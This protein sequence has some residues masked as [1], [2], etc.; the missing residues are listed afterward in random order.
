MSGKHLSQGVPRI[1]VV[2]WALTQ[3]VGGS[4]DPDPVTEGG[5]FFLL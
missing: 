3:Q 4:C 2:W 1:S 5:P